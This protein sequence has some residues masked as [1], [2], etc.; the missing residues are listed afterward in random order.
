MRKIAVYHMKRF[1]TLRMQLSQK[2]TPR[3][4]WKRPH[5]PRSLNVISTGCGKRFSSQSELIAHMDKESAD[6][7]QAIYK[8]AEDDQG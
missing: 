5:R 4:P 1:K 6:A 2:T 7:R 8:D 3:I